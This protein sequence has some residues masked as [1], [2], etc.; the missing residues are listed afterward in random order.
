M[1][2]A[3][4]FAWVQHLRGEQAV[5]FKAELRRRLQVMPSGLRIRNLR[6]LLGW[7]QRMAAVQLGIS[8]RTVI[9]HE[10][11]RN[12]HP[13]WPRLSLLRRLRELESDYAEELIAYLA[14]GGREH[15]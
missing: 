1:M 9:R 13:Q 15:A 6:A 3:G 14:R 5:H 7:T 8:V 4:D 2:K 11:G 12:R 10:Q